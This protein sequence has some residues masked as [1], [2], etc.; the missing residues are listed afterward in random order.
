M[1]SDFV[2]CFLKQYIR[3]RYIQK[4]F[5]DGNRINTNMIHSTAVLGKNIYLAKEVDVRE[6]VKIQD[7]SYCSP[8]T[9]LFQGTEIGRYCSIGYNVQI[10]CPE[11]PVSFL[12]TS[13]TV[14]RNDD[15]KQYCSWPS[16]DIKE[17]AKIGNDV[18]IGSNA[19]VLQGVRIGNGAIVAAGAVVTKDVPAFSIVAGVPAKI[20]KKRFNE[21]MEKKINESKWWEKSVSEVEKIVEELYGGDTK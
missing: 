15:I 14:Y 2:P 9:I 20:I 7:Y 18:W 1:L 4:K 19:I 12:S 17:P 10:S 6:N 3:K 11:H 16:D 21:V 5:G 8:R 13:P